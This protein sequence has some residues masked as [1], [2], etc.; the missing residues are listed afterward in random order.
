[1]LFASLISFACGGGGGSGSNATPA[2]APP[3]YTCTNGTPVPTEDDTELEENIEK[4]A[5]CNDGFVITQELC[6]IGYSPVCNSGGTPKSEPL[7]EVENFE[8][9]AS[10]GD[11]ETAPMLDTNDNSICSGYA[12]DYPYICS[13]GTAETDSMGNKMA[14]LQKCTAC[15]AGFA[16]VNVLSGDAAI[17]DF[18]ECRKEY[19][20]ICPD[21]TATVGATFEENTI[22]CTSCDTGFTLSDSQCIAMTLSTDHLGIWVGHTATKGGF[23]FDY[24]QNT[25]L[26]PSGNMGAQAA[27]DAGHTY[28]RF[29]GSTSSY[30]LGF[31]KDDPDGI[32]SEKNMMTD[33][34]GMR[35]TTA[36][37]K[38]VSIIAY[39]SDGTPTSYASFFAKDLTLSATNSTALSAD[40]IEAIFLTGLGISANATF[41][42]FTGLGNDSGYYAEYGDIN[43]NTC[44]GATVST[45]YAADRSVGTAKG[46]RGRIE[47]S[48]VKYYIGGNNCN[49]SNIV[50]CVSR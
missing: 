47:A 16:L 42:T 21:G 8:D 31:A 24:C 34:A 33:D 7:R 49:N 32:D 11:A 48:A 18:M 39:K 25:I 46:S 30:N 3:A 44:F 28:A 4:C 50:L 35:Y 37:S 26:N 6:R 40:G 41:W 9:C 38:S 27:K 20:Y 1:M 45:E 43:T 36:Q 19:A 29:Y 15:D 2:P 13:N 23:G 12:G 14:N 10:C 17:S 5:S 22:K